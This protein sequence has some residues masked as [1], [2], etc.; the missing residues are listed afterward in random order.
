MENLA[1]DQSPFFGR[2]FC[3]TIAKHSGYGP[4]LVYAVMEEIR[5]D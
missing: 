3:V 4:I 2:C 5:A 1:S